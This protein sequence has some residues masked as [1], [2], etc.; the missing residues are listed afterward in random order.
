MNRYLRKSSS[1]DTRAGG[2][3]I[4]IA[5]TCLSYSYKVRE[6]RGVSVSIGCVILKSATKQFAVTCDRS[7][8]ASDYVK[9]AAE[10]LRA[11]WLGNGV[12]RT[13]DIPVTVLW[14]EPKPP[15]SSVRCRNDRRHR[16]GNRR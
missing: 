10:A 6:K 16:P 5:P 1:F 14:V 2:I 9:I 7:D 12:V 15:W 8:G 13:P 4:R 3:Y 11:T